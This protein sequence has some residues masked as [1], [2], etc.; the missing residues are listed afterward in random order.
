[1]ES[2]YRRKKDFSELNE[3]L[4]FALLFEMDFLCW[5]QAQ[6]TAEL[7]TD[8]FYTFSLAEWLVLRWWWS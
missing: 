5:H 6:G 1:M 8:Q 7:T 2:V 3:A 4:G